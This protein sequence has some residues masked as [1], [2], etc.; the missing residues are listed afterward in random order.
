VVS[1]ASLPG[2]AIAFLV[3]ESIEPGRGKSLP[4]LLLGALVSGLCGM[5]LVKLILRWTRLKEDAAL[6]IVLSVFF[7]GGVV[8][9][10][11]IQDLPGGNAA[12]LNQFIFGKTASMVANDVWLTAAVAAATLLMIV[13]MFKELTLLS[14]DERFAAACGWPVF[15]LDLVLMALVTIVTVIGLQSVGLLLVVALLIIPAAAARFWTDRLRAMTAISGTLGGLS[16]ASGVV[17]SALFP[18]LAAGAIIVLSGTVLFILSL[19]FGTRRGL[20][21]RAIAHR[22]LRVEVG[23]QHLLRAM[24]ECAEIETQPIA[25]SV[26][27]LTQRSISFRGLQSV[28]SWPPNR[29]RSL[30]S[31]ADRE[32][33]VTRT[34]PDTFRLTPAGAEAACRVVRNHRLWELFLIEHAD[35]DPTHVDRDADD[36]EHWLGPDV[37]Q[38]LERL[39]A[40]RYPALAIPPSPHAVAF[41]GAGPSGPVSDS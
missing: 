29:L 27:A 9:L 4:V 8:L 18:R 10:T 2:I 21:V 5:L 36:I 17:L 1:H 39:V 26:P 20:V 30:L 25:D 22:R 35:I 19:L 37:V 12:G 38:E 14:F 34:S 13:S 3:L 31:V 32:G 11:V 28:R 7:G 23:R 24:F 16:A 33:L 6:A 40:K 15:S 41:S